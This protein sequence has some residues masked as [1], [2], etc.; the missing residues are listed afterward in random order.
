MSGLGVVD[1]S[2][3]ASINGTGAQTARG[4]ADEIGTN[5][6]TLLVTQLKNQDPLKPMENKELTSQ[7]AQI[8]TVNGIEELNKTLNDIDSQIGVGQQLQAAT[9]IGRGVMVSGSRVL[10]GNDGIAT[11]FGVE[12]ERAANAAQVYLQSETGEI[13]RRFDLGAMPAGNDT[14]V[15]D[16]HLDNGELAPAGAYRVVVDARGEGGQPVPAIT[17]NYALVNGVSASSSGEALLDIGGVAEPV[18]LS[19]VRQIL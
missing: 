18:R 10:V 5:F 1:P 11:P 6:M 14:L 15:W 3:L 17:L 12:L 13:V 7:L 19:D 16:G 9:L 8:N 4:V 2:V